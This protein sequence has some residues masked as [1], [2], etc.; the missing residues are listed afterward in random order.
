M[1]VYLLL[2]F[3]L[4]NESTVSVT[5]YKIAGRTASGILTTEAGEP[6]VAISRDLLKEYPMGSYITLSNCK[7]SGV[8]KVLDKMGRRHKKSIDVY[9]VVGKGSKTTCTCNKYFIQ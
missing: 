8:Y 5:H 9:D 7:W 2:M 1:I 6:F 3:F 4:Q